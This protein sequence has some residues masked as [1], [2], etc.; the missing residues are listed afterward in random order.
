MIWYL[1]FYSKSYCN[2][3]N[4]DK[5]YVCVVVV[6]TI[7]NVFIKIIIHNIVFFKSSFYIAFVHLSSIDKKICSSDV[8]EP[9]VS[10]LQDT[11][12]H[13]LL[14][15]LNHY[16]ET[17]YEMTHCRELKLSSNTTNNTNTT[18]NNITNTTTNIIITNTVNSNITNTTSLVI[19]EFEKQ[20]TIT[21]FKSLQ[22]MMSKNT[23]KSLQELLV[24]LHN[25]FDNLLIVPYSKLRSFN[26]MIKS[27][28][29]C[30]CSIV[31]RIK[32]DLSDDFVEVVYVLLIQS[33]C[34]AIEL[35]LTTNWE[36]TSTLSRLIYAMLALTQGDNNN[37]N[38]CIEYV[39]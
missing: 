10:E 2:D 8:D 25:L 19:T 9:I 6:Y 17:L 4:N 33:V 22:R 5:Y 32:S 26:Y 13:Y 14:Q 21:I 36:H 38:T 28:V 37:N 35:I 16:A 29:E 23:T 34:K 30:L 15:R 1:Q 27:A 3:N 24:I 39:A 12:S 31:D 18:T 11:A 7:F 20:A